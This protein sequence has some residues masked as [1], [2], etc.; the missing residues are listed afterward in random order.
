MRKRARVDA[1]HAEIV[2]VFRAT[3]CSVQSLATLGHGV[4]DL[5]VGSDGY[6]VLVEVKAPSGQRNLLQ[7]QFDHEWRGWIEVVRT[8]DDAL[9]LVKRLRA[10]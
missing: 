8:P 2:S 4:P 3:G 9:A 5:I 10:L 6:N 7:R 1:N